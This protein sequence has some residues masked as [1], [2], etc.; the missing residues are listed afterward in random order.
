MTPV[1]HLTKKHQYPGWVGSPE[2]LKTLL[3]HLEASFED[4]LATHVARKTRYSRTSLEEATT[5][6]RDTKEQMEGT[7]GAVLAQF[8]SRLRFDESEMR[9]LSS[10]LEVDE[11]DARK[12]LQLKADLYHKEGTTRSVEGTADEL[13][14]TIQAY[15]RFTRLHVQAPSG[16]VFSHRA[17]LLFDDDGLEA[18]VNSSHNT[19]AEGTHAHMADLIKPQIPNW[20]LVRNPLFSGFFGGRCRLRNHLLSYD[21]GG[22]SG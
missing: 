13:M 5:R 14:T 16:A 2:A 6:V 18:Y 10:Q 1:E 7:T 21:V 3:V 4:V 20:Q 15:K 12:D 17:A 19:W 22:R 9:R 11:A 8:E